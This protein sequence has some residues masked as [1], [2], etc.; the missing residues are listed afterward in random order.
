M[1]R[2]FPDRHFFFVPVTIGLAFQAALPPTTWH[3]DSNAGLPAADPLLRDQ[4]G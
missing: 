4:T 2:R 1:R 3:R